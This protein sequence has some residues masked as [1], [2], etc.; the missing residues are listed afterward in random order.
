MDCL[1][2]AGGGL[3]RQERA[4]QPPRQPRGGVADEPAG[5]AVAAET[6][7]DQQVD[8]GGVGR[9]RDQCVRVA[10]GDQQAR[11]FGERWQPL[12]GLR[13]QL[14]Q[15]LAGLAARRDHV[16]GTGEPAQQAVGGRRSAHGEQVEARAEARGQGHGV[17]DD[18]GIERPLHRVAVLQVDRRQ[19]RP[20][21]AAGASVE[22]DRQRG[23]TEQLVELALFRLGAGAAFG[24]DHEVVAA[25]RLVHRF[26][27]VSAEQ[28]VS[29]L[30]TAE[31]RRQGVA[32]LREQLGARLLVDAVPALQGVGEGQTPADAA[33]QVDGTGQ[34]AGR[35]AAVPP[36]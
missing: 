26:G 27:Q 7:G 12:A 3:D 4:G 9:L 21:G 10:L 29:G 5:Q 16:V 36:K 20:R 11:L 25:G 2:A 24:R 34:Q 13:E 22:P 1:E 17:T 8:G 6:A 14:V 19:D 30:S 35:R 23:A 28:P 15:P 18:A 32:Q 31:V 33:R